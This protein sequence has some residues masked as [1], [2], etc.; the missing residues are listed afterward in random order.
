MNALRPSG[1]LVAALFLCSCEDR[2]VD[3]RGTNDETSTFYLA[4]GQKAANASVFVYP[5]NSADSLPAMTAYTDANGQLELPGLDRGLYSLVVRHASGRAVFVDSVFSNGEEATIPSDTL[6]P[7][8]NLRGRLKVQENH[9]AKI[10]WLFLK[11]AGIYKNVGDSG[12]FL[13]E[14]VPPGRYTI[15]ACTDRD[16][17]TTTTRAVAVLSDSTVDIGTIE[18]VFTGLPIVTG[19]VGTWDSLAGAV[20]VSWDP[21]ASSKVVGYEIWRSTTNDPLSEQRLGYVDSRIASWTD[22]VFPSNSA[23][24][25]SKTFV[26]Y[27]VAPVAQNGKPGDLW[28]S[29]TDSLRPPFLVATLAA[30]WTPV[31]SSAPNSPI[32]LDT[33]SGGLVMVEHLEE[34]TVIS[35]STDGAT[36]RKVREERIQPDPRSKANGPSLGVS[37][38]GK[39]W[40]VRKGSGTRTAPYGTSMEVSQTLLDSLRILSMDAT[41]RID[42]STHP[43]SGDSVSAGYLWL[44]SS[45]MVLVEGLILPSPVTNQELITTRYA[46]FVESDRSLGSDA[47][48]DWYPQMRVVSPSGL[49]M[50]NA[51]VTRIGWY[52]P[53][54]PFEPYQLHLDSLLIG[55]NGLW[56]ARP[57]ALNN[58]H[59][60]EAPAEAAPSA[61]AWWRGRIWAA[62]SGK[63]WT[64]DLPDRLPLAE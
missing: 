26:R 6:L 57:W 30:K 64:I 29:W 42:S 33:V 58:P 54:R 39:F 48:V 47:P 50:V 22:T 62:G 12:E 24:E 37:F 2:T 20:E 60:I 19:I 49:S 25:A 31:S 61:I 28:N 63:V 10:A 34:T 1:I 46:H 45:G 52:N 23:F 38:D 27:R 59:R 35:L 40:W 21:S 9:D 17:Y 53:Y 36:W 11:G 16:D 41:G 43:V 44:D 32:R 56:Y 13:L 15:F 55:G 51:M 4:D 5:S 3:A 8:G 14:G 7:T 18:L